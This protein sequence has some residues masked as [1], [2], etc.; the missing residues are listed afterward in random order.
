MRVA[1]SVSPSDCAEC[2][3]CSYVVQVIKGTAPVSS[4]PVP[5]LYDVTW[6]VDGKTESFENPAA[7]LPGVSW[8]VRAFLT[9]P[10]ALI[11]LMYIQPKA[12]AA[13]SACYS[14]LSAVHGSLPP[15]NSKGA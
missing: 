11:Y 10:L 12:E 9:P 3:K 14:L 8:V 7:R 2:L 1:N 5:Y 13:R 15:K 4:V 6:Q